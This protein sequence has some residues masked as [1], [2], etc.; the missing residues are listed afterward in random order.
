MTGVAGHPAGALADTWVQTFA[1]PRA[2]RLLTPGVTREGGAP[3]C[4]LASRPVRTE[5]GDG[6]AG[7]YQTLP[8]AKQDAFLERAGGGWDDL[9]RDYVLHVWS[10]A[11]GDRAG[12]LT[13]AAPVE[14]GTPPTSRVLAAYADFMASDAALESIPT[15]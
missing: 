13:I 1:S 3:W 2:A 7:S 5:T 12:L 4:R 9:P 10:L 14:A 6:V 15:F 8:L 11:R